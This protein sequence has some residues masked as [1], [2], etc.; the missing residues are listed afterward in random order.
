MEM[1]FFVDNLRFASVRIR[2]RDIANKLGYRIVND[3]NFSN[4]ICIFIKHIPDINTLIDLKKK[5]N[6]LILDILDST[7]CVLNVQQYF[8]YLITNN[9]SMNKD[10]NTKTFTIYHQMDEFGFEKYK[11]GINIKNGLVC[12]CGTLSKT[13]Y[14]EKFNDLEIKHINS[15]RNCLRRKNPLG[16]IMFSS[17]KTSRIDEG[18]IPV[19]WET[20]TKLA[21]SCYFNNIF[22]TTKTN[23]SLELLGADYSYYIP[24]FDLESVKKIITKCK[25]DIDEK[26]NDYMKAKQ[27]LEIVKKQL[28]IDSISKKYIDLHNLINNLLI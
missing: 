5:N 11:N 3:Y 17:K 25:N 14:S 1:V 19:E 24:E 15:I 21:T 22:I 27:K 18:I 7:N 9:L 12:Y 4:K 2:G 10:F 8:D 16:S 28:S 26:N 13:N 23:C 6:I 20:S